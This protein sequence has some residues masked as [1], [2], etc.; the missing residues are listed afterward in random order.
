MDQ[1]GS[2]GAAT[3]EGVALIELLIKWRTADE[4]VDLFACCLEG[5]Y[6][7]QGIDMAMYVQAALDATPFGVEYPSP[8]PGTSVPADWVCL[9]EA[10]LVTRS[11]A[12]QLRYRTGVAGGPRSPAISSQPLCPYNTDSKAPSLAL[13][14]KL[15]CKSL[16]VMSRCGA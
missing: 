7:P 4:T 1:L 2:I 10:M 12:R 15:R 9:F 8:L 3:A 5:L 6:S 13:P 16:T 14:W 11:I